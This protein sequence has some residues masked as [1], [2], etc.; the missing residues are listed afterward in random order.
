[1]ETAI[2]AAIHNLRV[3]SCHHLS[4]ACCQQQHHPKRELQIDSMMKE[5]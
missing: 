4:Q 5:S 3:L 1:M 2:D